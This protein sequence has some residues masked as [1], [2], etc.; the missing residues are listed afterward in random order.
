MYKYINENLV[1]CSKMH[2]EIHIGKNFNWIQTFEVLIVLV[3]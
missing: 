3:S 1:E 2:Y